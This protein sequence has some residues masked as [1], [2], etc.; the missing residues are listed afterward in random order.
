MQLVLFLIKDLAGWQQQDQNN[1]TESDVQ[2]RSRANQGAQVINTT[3][4][5]LFEELDAA[6]RPCSLALNGVSDLNF[7]FYWSPGDWQS[8]TGNTMYFRMQKNILSFTRKN[9][10]IFDVLISE[11][12]INFSLCSKCFPSPFPHLI[13]ATWIYFPSS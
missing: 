3:E 5:E 11:D 9:C 13:S 12:M 2:G 1:L 6:I 10:T 4:W 7:G 8:I